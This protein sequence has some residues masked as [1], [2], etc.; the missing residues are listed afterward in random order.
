MPMYHHLLFSFFLPLR[1]DYL[2]R[3]PGQGGGGVSCTGLGRYAL[4]HRKAAGGSWVIPAR[5]HPA[6]HEQGAGD[7]CERRPGGTP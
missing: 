3:R 5:L 4:T 7:P 6:R 2:P 1:F